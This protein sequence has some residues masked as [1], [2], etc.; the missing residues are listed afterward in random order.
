MCG[1]TDFFEEGDFFIFSSVKVGCVLTK[2]DG[3]D[4]LFLIE[5]TDGVPKGT[6]EAGDR[7]ACGCAREERKQT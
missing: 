1:V 4:I 6:A 5:N 3:C 7:N 2:A